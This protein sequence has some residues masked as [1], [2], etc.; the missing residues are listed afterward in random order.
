MYVAKIFIAFIDEDDEMSRMKK[1]EKRKTVVLMRTAKKKP[2]TN[3]YVQFMSRVHAQ[4][5]GVFGISE[6]QP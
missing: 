3:T 6:Q 4:N 1:F 5:D 2:F